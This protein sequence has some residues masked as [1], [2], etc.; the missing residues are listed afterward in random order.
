MSQLHHE[1]QINI[2]DNDNEPMNN[3]Q[4]SN[5]KKLGRPADKVWDYF[6]KGNSVSKG[7]WRATCKFCGFDFKKGCT[8]DMQEHL[9]LY[10]DKVTKRVGDYYSAF[11]ALRDGSTGEPTQAVGKR[12]KIN[13]PNQSKLT[14]HLD[15]VN[16][17][18][19]RK[20]RI[21]Q[22]LI[23]AFVCS[24][25]PFKAVENPFIIDLFKELNAGYQPPSNEHLSKRLLNQEVAKINNAINNELKYEVNLTLGM[26]LLL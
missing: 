23:R 1:N 21:D 22:A 18:H 17:N 24:G 2:T 7:H 19:G 4:I 11:V 26:L 6:L 5:I 10:C 3:D 15:F 13:D 12:R 16:M 9:G 20:K 14:E 25:I 8:L